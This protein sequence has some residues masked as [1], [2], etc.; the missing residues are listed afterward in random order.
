MPKIQQLREVVS[1]KLG[2]HGS[3]L[4]KNAVLAGGTRA[5]GMVVGFALLMFVSQRY[6]EVGA[7]YFTVPQSLLIV[8]RIVV[9]MGLGLAMVR[10]IAQLPDKERWSRYAAALR[11]VTPVSFGVGFLIVLGA[12]W[13]ASFVFRNPDLRWPIVAVGIA[14][15]F[16]TITQL[17]AEVARGLRRMVV[18]GLFRD[19]GIPFIALVLFLVLLGSS[20][21]GAFYAF[22]I[23]CGVLALISTIHIVRRLRRSRDESQVQTR[24]LL[25]LSLPMMVGEFGIILLGRTDH[26]MLEMLGSTEDAG[27]Y[28][29]VLRLS[30]L[31]LFLPGAVGAIAAP[32]IAAIFAN[33]DAAE[34]RKVALMV[35]RFMFWSALLPTVIFSV[36]PGFWLG[37]FGEGFERG[38]FALII[39]CLASLI[40]ASTGFVGSILNMTGSE[41]FYRNLIIAVFATNIVLN[42]AL[43]PILE[44]QGAA[45]ASLVSAV[46]LNTVAVIHIHRRHG[47]WLIHIPFW[48]R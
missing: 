24:Q 43:I 23:G 19:A 6:G 36:S 5:F 41:K 32:K 33:K 20:E 17:N 44:L 2:D 48:P 31:V 15:P 22:A 8:L 7:S 39:L 21:K 28:G 3:D 9:S 30:G 13:I 11:G 10:L 18:S 46:L 34:F 12:P 42:V 29:V 4:I 1:R 35:A 27:V 40:A 47:F 14:L 37:W 38:G 45:L 25:Q 26:I 16:F